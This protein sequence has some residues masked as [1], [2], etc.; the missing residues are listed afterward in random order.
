MVARYVKNHRVPMNFYIDCKGY[1]R[2]RCE[3]RFGRRKYHCDWVVEGHWVLDII[4]DGSDNLHLELCPR[5]LSKCENTRSA[6]Q[7]SCGPQQC[8]PHWL[9]AGLSNFGYQ[10]KVVNHSTEFVK[11]DGVPTNYMESAATSGTTH[12]LTAW[13]DT[14]G[15][16]FVIAV[17]WTSS[18]P[19]LTTSAVSSLFA[20]LSRPNSTARRVH[21]LKW[22]RGNPL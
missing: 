16:E 18:R 5:K 7:T 17:V 10:H 19:S 1:V 11:A 4:A 3:A 14:S 8:H 22:W 2:F 20:L 12:L 15:G 13:L 21:A 9:V 6:R